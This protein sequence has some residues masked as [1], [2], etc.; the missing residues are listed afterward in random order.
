MKN[1]KIIDLFSGI[2]GF[3]LGFKLE[4]FEVVVANEIDNEIAESYKK[5]FPSVKMIN[6]DI[7]KLKL[8]IAFKDLKNNIAVVIGG[9]PCQGFSQKGKRNFLED[10]RN[11]L[12]RYFFDVVKYINPKY[13]VIE[14][15]PALLTNSNKKFKKEIYY[16]F[17]SIGYS[18]E[19]GIL[20]TADFGIPQQRKR[21]FIIGKKGRKS[22]NLPSVKHKFVTVWDAISDLSYLNSGEGEFETEYK[23]L[24]ETY[25]QEF[26]RKNSNILYNHQA[27]KHTKIA[28]ERIKLIPENGDRKNLPEHHQTKSIFSGTWGRINKNGHSVTITTR[29]DT[30]SS[31]RFIH[32][33]LNRAITVREAARIQGFPD[34]IIFFG[35]KSSQMKQV[36]NAVSPI[37]SREIAKIIKKDMEENYE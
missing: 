14:N 19:S 5:N 33:V 6:E 17:E 16:I 28:L 1:N 31:G 37:L 34:K 24:S 2:G 7:T 12:F 15:V 30:P 13:F 29:F 4:N 3:S 8:D 36:G 10:S 9:P 35:S 22:L 23:N 18:L 27:T 20:N 21:A 26:L 25:Y 32:P 11:Y